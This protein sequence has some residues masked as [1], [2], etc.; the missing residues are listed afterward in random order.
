MYRIHGEDQFNCKYHDILEWVGV[1]KINVPGIIQT[2]NAFI[3]IGFPPIWSYFLW[4]YTI[5]SFLWLAL[6]VVINIFQSGRSYL[7]T[8]CIKENFVSVIVV[9][10]GNHRRVAKKLYV[11]LNTCMKNL[12]DF[13]NEG[14]ILKMFTF[15]FILSFHFFSYS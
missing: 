4:I 10:Y 9:N 2:W 1:E 7:H 15:N 6:D 12:N 8:G 13:K 11:I 14:K 3:K 5:V